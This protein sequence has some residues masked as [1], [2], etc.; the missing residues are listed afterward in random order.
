MYSLRKEESC[1]SFVPDF[2]EAETAYTVRVRAELNKK[3]ECERSEEANFISPEFSEC[4]V[5][6]ECPDNVEEKRKYSVDE[7]NT[8]VATKTSGYGYCTVIG[9]TPLPLN[10]VTSWNIKIL[11]SED[12]DGRGIFIGVAPSDINQNEDCNQWKSGWYFS[13]YRSTLWSRSPHNYIGKEYG[14]SKEDGKYI[15]TGDSAGVVMDTTKGE[16]SFVLSGVNL[17]V[18][19]DGIPLD[20]P[21]VPCVTLWYKGDSVEL[22]I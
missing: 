11:K 14:P 1:F 18:A 17:G 4:C 6:K 16:L 7:K 12:N 21:L 8:R 9:N 22:I 10:K 15:Q 20:K 13:C 5:W 3:K 2:L 19:Y